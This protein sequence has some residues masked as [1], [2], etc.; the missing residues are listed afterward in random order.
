MAQSQISINALRESEHI[1]ESLEYLKDCSTLRL[2]YI[3][4]HDA[5]LLLSLPCVKAVFI[6]K[7]KYGTHVKYVPDDDG[8]FNDVHA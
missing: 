1:K 4:P 5:Q 8:I 2:K 3:D 7:G 6:F